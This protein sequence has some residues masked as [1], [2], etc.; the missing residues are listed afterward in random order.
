MTMTNDELAEAVK[1]I[2]ELQSKTLPDGVM[3]AQALGHNI[4]MLKQECDNMAAIIAQLWAEREQQRAAM[5][6]A[7]EAL[8]TIDGHGLARTSPMR[9]EQRKQA[10]ALAKPLLGKREGV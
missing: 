3:D 9:E 2:A 8:E 10:L 4:F 5:V 6:K 1:R 7:K